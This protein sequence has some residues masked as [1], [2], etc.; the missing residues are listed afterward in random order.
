V[1]RN[2]RVARAT[3]TARRGADV[4]VFAAFAGPLYNGKGVAGGAELQSFYLARSLARAGF[5]V[6]HVVAAV[7][8]TRTEDGVEVVPLSAGYARRGFTRRRAI[9]RALREADGRVYIQRC[10]GMETG[11]VGLFAR[12]ARRR[13]VFSASSDA[14]F[15]RDTTMMGQMGGSLEEWPTRLQYRVGLRCVHAVVAQTEKQAELARRS[16]GLDP[17]VIRSF[18]APARVDTA[19]REGF[20]WIGSL[21]DVKDPIAF[22]AL[23]ERMPD[24]RFRMIATDH[25]AGWQELAATVRSRARRLP[26]LELLPPR[27]RHELLDLYQ[28]SIAVV[29]TSRFEGF[30][31]T[32]LEAW[33]H[34][35]PALSL[36]LDPDDV[37]SRHGLGVAAGGSLEV[38]ARRVR[39]YAADPAVARAAGEAAYRYIERRHAPEVVGPQ[40]ASLVERLLRKSS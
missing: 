40:W 21:V 30:P 24:V 9:V 13:F 19:A 12:V 35:V 20:L 14:D 37:I 11:V 22:L 7:D 38:L 26:N 10:A 15:T 18:C 16:F 34:A 6:R 29:N 39:D 8:A 23:V 1:G 31:N 2:R 17:H 33:G 32:F 25:P 4:V 28:R 5:R 36:R 27:P 3:G